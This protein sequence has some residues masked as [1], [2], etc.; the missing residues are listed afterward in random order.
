MN[1]PEL[2][3]A[4]SP[5]GRPQVPSGGS[6]QNNSDDG[7][8]FQSTVDSA[9]EDSQRS[10]SEPTVQNGDEARDTETIAKDPG[11]HEDTP[12]AGPA[13]LPDSNNLGVLPGNQAQS[14]VSLALHGEANTK[15]KPPSDAIRTAPSPNNTVVASA[16]VRSNVAVKPGAEPAVT[17]EESLD[18][19]AASSSNTKPSKRPSILPVTASPQPT[20]DGTVTLATQGEPSTASATDLR[21]SGA[22]ASSQAAT[23]ARVNVEQPNSSNRS[24][25]ASRQSVEVKEQKAS[26]SLDVQTSDGEDSGEA[27][28][29]ERLVER[30]NEVRSADANRADRS[31]PLQ[32]GTPGPAQSVRYISASPISAV[33]FSQTTSSTQTN[34]VSAQATFA[35]E[36][37]V[38]RLSVPNATP[39]GNVDG[40]ARHTV[41]QIAAAIRNQPLVQTVELSLDP[42][43]LG[44]IEI[45]MDLGETGLKATLSAERTAT[46]DLIR[47]QSE[48]LQQ[49]LSEAGFSDVDLEFRD[50]ESGE[51]Q[52]SRDEDSRKHS[53]VRSSEALTAAKPQSN[54]ILMRLSASGMDVRL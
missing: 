28:R 19:D 42:P 17:V 5:F 37:V 31:I 27:Q 52:Q 53:E 46:G 41:A 12:D 11:V 54:Q 35:R 20:R 29:D 34:T 39:A 30:R 22:T 6:N 33:K 13:K 16:V 49:Q 36:I 14:K 21:Q 23:L 43:E 7:G 18:A 47:R 4:N 51:D 48:L 50:F 1:L 32:N 15:A 3:G 45:Q 24:D 25:L 26:A 44:R 40:P 10:T 9:V 38:E 2:L 8:T